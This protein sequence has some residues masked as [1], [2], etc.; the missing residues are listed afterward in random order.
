MSRTGTR[1]TTEDDDEA[2]EVARVAGDVLPMVEVEALRR[3]TVKERDQTVDR[4]H[5]AASTVNAHPP[6]YVVK[7]PLEVAGDDDD[8]DLSVIRHEVLEAEVLCILESFRVMTLH[9]SSSSLATQDD[10]LFKPGRYC[11]TARDSRVPWI[12]L[13]SSLVHQ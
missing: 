13:S 1:A 7:T 5:R 2:W 8:N 10:S 4:A 3:C 12:S 9:L 11:S 6:R